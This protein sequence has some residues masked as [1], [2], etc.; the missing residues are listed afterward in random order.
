MHVHTQKKKSHGCIEKKRT[1]SGFGSIIAAVGEKEA[2]GDKIP[3][4]QPQEGKGHK[5]VNGQGKTKYSRRNGGRCTSALKRPLEKSPIYCKI[6]KGLDSS[7]GWERNTF[8]PRKGD[9]KSLRHRGKEFS[10]QPKRK[11][12]TSPGKGVEKGSLIILE[13]AH[14]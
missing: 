14:P 1:R 11:N 2:Y 6:E 3:R 4:P 7:I 5:A 13:G 9:G 12:P 8:A 10:S